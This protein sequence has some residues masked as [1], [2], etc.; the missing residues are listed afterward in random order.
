MTSL[1]T[2]DKRTGRSASVH[3]HYTMINESGIKLT[4][5]FYKDQKDHT[6]TFIHIEYIE[7]RREERKRRQK[8]KRNERKRRRGPR[9][10]EGREEGSKERRK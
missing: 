10:K 5:T 3:I 2:F 9:R 4:Y 6:R 1:D 8:K 7:G